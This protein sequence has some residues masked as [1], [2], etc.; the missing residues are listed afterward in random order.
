MPMRIPMQR[1]ITNCCGASSYPFPRAPTLVKETQYFLI[2]IALKRL[3]VLSVAD[4]KYAFFGELEVESLA[5]FFIQEH[6]IF[7]WL[8][9]ALKGGS[10]R[11]HGRF[12][13]RLHKE[14]QCIDGGFGIRSKRGQRT[15]RFDVLL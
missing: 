14:A 6:A 12:V 13:A 10:C 3:E 7:G 8:Q 15:N 1:S 2:N 9:D 4:R 5:E 11:D